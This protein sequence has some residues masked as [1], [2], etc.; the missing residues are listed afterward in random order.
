MTEGCHGAP[1]GALATVATVTDVRH[2]TT[3]RVVRVL[4]PG[5]RWRQ[6]PRNP[7]RLA[8]ATAMQ[9]IATTLGYSETIFI[10]EP[11]DDGIDRCAHL[12]AGQRAAL[13][14][15]STRRCHL[16]PRRTAGA[17][18]R[19]VAESAS[20]RPSA[21]RRHGEHRGRL[22]P[23]GRSDDR[24]RRRRRHGS[25]RCRSPTRCIVSRA[26]RP[27]P[28][29]GSSDRPDHRLVWAGGED[30]SDDIVRAR[31]FAPVMGV[32]ED[33]ATGSA[34]VAL[35]AVL[36]HEGRRSGALTIHQGAEIGCPSR[37]DLS[38]TATDTTCRRD[39]G[40][41][42]STDGQRPARLVSQAPTSTSP[43]P[44]IGEAATCSSRN[45]T[46]RPR[47]TTGMR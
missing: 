30:G 2:R 47:A 21:R 29:M 10:D 36:R 14:R 23:A 38:W 19:C 12:H 46:P 3:V 11:G 40:G 22:P 7:R 18:S 35:A 25:P 4:H 17:A 32:V 15:A 33:P 16:A 20:Y 41:R 34:A 31:F 5:R 42:R 24:A 13:R 45:T 27:S 9:S 28:T 26:R 1:C 44:A 8:P 43:R 37:I 6:P 39:G